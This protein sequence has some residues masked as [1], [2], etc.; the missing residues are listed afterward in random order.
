MDGVDDEELHSWDE[1]GV[2]GSRFSDLQALSVDPPKC[3]IPRV[4][5]KTDEEGFLFGF[6]RFISVL[7]V[8]KWMVLMPSR[9]HYRAKFYTWYF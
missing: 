3:N 9:V 8:E 6:W 7:G 4:I 5:S 1:S 2:L